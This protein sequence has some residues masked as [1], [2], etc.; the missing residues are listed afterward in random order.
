MKIGHAKDRCWKL[1]GRPNRGRGGISGSN[2]SYGHLS[3]FPD[4]NRSFDD[5]NGNGL[6]IEDLQI[7][8][9]S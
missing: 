1:H 3:D 9:D 6:F 8:E 4:N 5:N 7:S 2:G